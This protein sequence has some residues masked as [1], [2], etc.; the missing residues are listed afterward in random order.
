MLNF[1]PRLL[2]ATARFLELGSRG[3]GEVEL[4]GSEL[5][6]PMDPRSQDP[7]GARLR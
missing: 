4:V 6:D 7:F 2:V 1:F 3:F 5:Q